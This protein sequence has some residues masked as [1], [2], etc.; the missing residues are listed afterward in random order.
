V[1]GKKSSYVCGLNFRINNCRATL[2]KEEGVYPSRRVQP[3]KKKKKKKKKKNGRRRR[4]M[5]RRAV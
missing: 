3:Q 2:Y 5:R 4:R 1:G